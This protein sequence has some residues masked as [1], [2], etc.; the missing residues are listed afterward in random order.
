MTQSL[1]HDLNV[2][3]IAGDKFLWFHRQGVSAKLLASLSPILVATGSRVGNRSF[4]PGAGESYVVF[5]EPED[6][7]FW[8]PKTDELLTLNG[9]SFALNEMHIGNAATYSFDGNLNIFGSVL[10]WLRA[11][12]D[13]IVVLDWRHAF[14]RLRDAPRI[15]VAE[16]LLP[17]YRKWMQPVRMPRLSVIPNLERAAA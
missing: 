13:G 16:N 7:I 12:C 11:G 15:A 1:L 9:R 3:P 14:D 4:N 17:N 10:D 8:Q 2:S 6:L 5:E